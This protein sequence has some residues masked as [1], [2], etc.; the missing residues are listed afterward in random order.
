MK[1]IHK[2]PFAIQDRIIIPMPFGAKIISVQLQRDIPGIWAIVDTDEEL[3]A[4]LI[5]C[6]GTGQPLPDDV[7]A[8]P[9]I[10]SIQSRNDSLVF[11]FFEGVVS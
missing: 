10:G 3:C 6:F 4:K 5:Y 9:Y 1:R 11:H 8:M 2:Y 7:T